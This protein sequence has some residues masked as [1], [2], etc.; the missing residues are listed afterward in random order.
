MVL[1]LVGSAIGSILNRNAQKKTNRQNKKMVDKTN[2][3]NER[4]AR[5]AT[6]ANERMALDAF[7]RSVAH[8]AMVNERTLGE[9]A[10]QFVRMRAAAEA[11]GLNPLTALGAGNFV[12]GGTSIT[13]GAGQALASTSVAAQNA[14]ALVS[15]DAIAQGFSDLGQELTGQAARDRAEQTA[16]TDLMRI[17]AET[18]R[19]GGAVERIA[20]APGAASLRVGASAPAARTS[21][22][23]LAAGPGVMS[24]GPEMPPRPYPVGP[25]P[26]PNVVEGSDGLTRSNPDIPAQPEEDLWVWFREGTILPNLDVALDR[27]IPGWMSGA[28]FGD[29]Y[30]PMVGDTL[31]TAATGVVRQFMPTLNP[32]ADVMNVRPQPIDHMGLRSDY[33]A[34]RG[35]SRAERERAGLPT[36][37]IGGEIYF[38]NRNNARPGVYSRGN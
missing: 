17:Q 5:E 8:E 21:Q 28:T 13:S 35:M 14:P 11:A 2:R 19:A 3:S 6:A 20:A 32:G 10:T 16:R 15:T 12:A 1:S 37:E 9:Q 4:M 27:N 22:P 7:N 18:M 34:W 36:S 33:D 24:E 23:S 26:G 31:A 30:G 38:R 29:R 25:N